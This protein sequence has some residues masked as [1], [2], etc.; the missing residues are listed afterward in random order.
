MLCEECGIRPKA[1]ERERSGK[2]TVH[3]Y[4]GRT[5]AQNAQRRSIPTCK[6]QGCNQPTMKGALFCSDS[7]AKKAVK[8]GE[9]DA[10]PFCKEFP[11]NPGFEFCSKQCAVRAAN[12]SARVGS[13]GNYGSGSAGPRT[14]GFGQGQEDLGGGPLRRLDQVD[15]VAGEVFK[16]F[17]DRWSDPARRPVVN[18]IFQ[19]LLSKRYDK[20]FTD[21]LSRG[22]TLGGFTPITTFYGGQCLCDLGVAP[23]VASPPLCNWPGCSICIVIRKGFDNLEFGAT[24]HDGMYNRGI[25][26]NMDPAHAH[27]FTVRKSTNPFRAIVV[28]SVVGPTSSSSQ[29]KKHPVFVDES[30]RVFCQTKDTVIPRQLIIYHVP[31]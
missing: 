13:S 16:K 25:Y 18:G 6:L 9:V 21:A 29:D 7:H 15:S 8:L 1:Q 11:V 17:Y 5:C 28:C 10:C 2:I 24:V 23:G 27:K 31:D 22:E 19:I 4:C 26:T 30:G 3:P 12:A 14:P 20:R